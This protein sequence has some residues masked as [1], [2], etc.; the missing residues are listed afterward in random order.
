MTFF[1]VFC[2]RKPVQIGLFFTF[3]FLALGFV[4]HID[5]LNLRPQKK[6]LPV[7]ITWIICVVLAIAAGML[8]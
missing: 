3:A 8:L 5:P 7:A 4:L 6:M 1:A 2:L